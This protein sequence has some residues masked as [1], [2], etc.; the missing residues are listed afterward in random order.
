MENYSVLYY[1]KWAIDSLIEDDRFSA[2]QQFRDTQR[3]ALFAHA[4]HLNRED[5]SVEERLRFIFEIAQ[6]IGKT[7]LELAIIGRIQTLAK[8]DGHTPKAL[9]IVPTELLMNQTYNKIKQFVP[10]MLESTG[11][12][13]AEHR[14]LSHDMTIIISDSFMS[15]IEAGVIN[16]DTY[17]II[18][19]D[20]GHNETSIRRVN[21]LTSTFE[22]TTDTLFLTMTATADFD[23]EKS[24]ELTHGDHRFSRG[25]VEAI[26][27]GE[28]LS[29]I[30]FALCHPPYNRNKRQQQMVL[31]DL[32]MKC[33]SK[34]GLIFQSCIMPMM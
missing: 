17:K 8:Q 21:N 12:Y 11:R 3:D 32:I 22:G 7:P 33:E 4:Q 19:S 6:G 31:Q 5:L 13:G 26:K 28:E 14:D 10:E 24:V 34:L 23:Q 27:N 25:M 1:A 9:L 16:P 2:G 30:C 18:V 20:E 15:L 29:F